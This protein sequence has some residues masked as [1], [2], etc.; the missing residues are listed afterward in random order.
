MGDDP[1][2]E[3]LEGFHTADYDAATETVTIS[4]HRYRLKA[5]D[6][7]MLLR[8]TSPTATRPSRRD[9]VRHCPGPAEL[10]QFLC[11][12]RVCP[13]GASRNAS[14]ASPTSPLAHLRSTS[15]SEMTS[16]CRLSLRGHAALAH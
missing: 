1:K 12:P 13:L 11:T 5:N 8:K 6:S 7:A 16:C 3:P 2:Q 14:M 10:I 4:V 15:A 9:V